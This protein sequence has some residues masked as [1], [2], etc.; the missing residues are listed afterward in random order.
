[1]DMD[2]FSAWLCVYHMSA[3]TPQ[4]QEKCARHL[5]IYSRQLRHHVGSRNHKFTQLTFQAFLSSFQA[6]L[7]CF[8][9]HH[10]KSTNI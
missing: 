2:N 6:V 1:M 8:F 9:P 3:Y 10:Q 7:S 5:E 4:R